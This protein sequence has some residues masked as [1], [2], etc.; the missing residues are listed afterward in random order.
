MTITYVREFFYVS[1][2]PLLECIGFDIDIS[3]G[4]AKMRASTLLGELFRLHHC[5]KTPLNYVHTN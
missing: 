5:T 4:V 3:D 2:H 1:R